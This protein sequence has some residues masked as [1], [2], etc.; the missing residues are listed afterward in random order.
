MLIQLTVYQSDMIKCPNI[1]S[2]QDLRA[3]SSIRETQKLSVS[4]SHEVFYAMSHNQ[5]QKAESSSRAELEWKH[6]ARID[7]KMF[8]NFCNISNFTCKKVY[9]LLT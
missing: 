4:K 2:V 3:V 5:S 1:A 8:A 6:F 9:T 7:D